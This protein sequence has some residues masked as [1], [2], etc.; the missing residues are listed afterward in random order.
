MR[1]AKQDELERLRVDY[2]RW[3]D[4][5]WQGSTR[6]DGWFAG[7]LNNASLL[8][9]G[10]YDQWVPAFAELVRRHNAD[11]QRFYWEVERLGSLAP[12]ERLGHLAVLADLDSNSGE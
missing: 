8:P 12:D 6:F 3:R 1:F 9:F 2:R 5:R 11:G 4:E 10:L 7:E